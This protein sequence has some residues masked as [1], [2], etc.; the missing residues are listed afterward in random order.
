MLTPV[1]TLDSIRTELLSLAEVCGFVDVTVSS[2][3]NQ[4]GTGYWAVAH[5]ADGQAQTLANSIRCATPAALRMAALGALYQ[6]AGTFG[7]SL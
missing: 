1:Y 6:Q 5:R 3:A 4:Y 7:A 2:S